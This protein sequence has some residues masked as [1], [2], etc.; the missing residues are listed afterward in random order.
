METLAYISYWALIALA[1]IWTLGVRIKLDAGV[2]VILG[3]LF[4][5][6]GAIA[7]GI[8]GADRLHSLWIIAAGFAFTF[9]MS[10]VGAY[11]PLLFAPFR[12]LASIFAR[13][14]RIGIPADRIK[15]AQEAGLKAFIDEWAKKVEGKK[16]NDA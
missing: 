13:V 2:A 5:L 3:A 7:I 1:A 11:L 6:A 12:L 4:F 15:A 9:V 8:S 10:Y 16:K 14:V